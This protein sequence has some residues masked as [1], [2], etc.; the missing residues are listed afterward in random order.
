MKR[1][2]KWMA[3]YTFPG[4]QSGFENGPAPHEDADITPADADP[5]AVPKNAA[6]RKGQV[7]EGHKLA[8]RF[9]E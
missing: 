3:S 2:A 5:L 7:P 1:G 8:K 6:L 9:A 4:D